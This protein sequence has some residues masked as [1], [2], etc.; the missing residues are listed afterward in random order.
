MY[1]RFIHLDTFS[2]SEMVSKNVPENVS[3]SMA[4][5]LTGNKTNVAAMVR[6]IRLQAKMHGLTDNRLP[7]SQSLA[8]V[9]FVLQSDYRVQN[10]PVS[11]IRA[12]NTAIVTRAGRKRRDKMQG[13]VVLTSN[14]SQ[15]ISQTKDSSLVEEVGSKAIIY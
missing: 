5:S 4:R 2:A 3:C 11:Q 13:A 15:A 8:Q 1:F 10:I 7:A 14:G 9:A 12:P 6:N